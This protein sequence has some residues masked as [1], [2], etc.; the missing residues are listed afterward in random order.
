MRSKSDDMF[1]KLRSVMRAEARPASIPDGLRV[2]AIG[3][4]HGR[5]D[6]LDALLERIDADDA[7][8][9]PLE[10][11]LIF[12]GD[13]I[14]RGPDSAAVVERAIT[15]ADAAPHTCF[16]MG[17]HEE[18]FLKVLGGDLAALKFFCRIGGRE[19]ILSYG[20]TATEYDEL[21]Y[22][23]LMAAVLELVPPAHRQFLARFVDMVEIGDYVFV[24]AG[25]RP[26]L[27]LAEQKPTDLR[28]IR[29]PFLGSNARH[30]KMVV[31]G[32][33]ITSQVEVRSN[34]IGI[35]TG[36]YVTGQLT[37][38]GFEGERWWPLLAD[39]TQLQH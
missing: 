34:R 24:H 6:L 5:R 32:H 12:L 31:H 8:R 36:A 2:Y 39:A 22:E 13:L 26:D 15:I 17:N 3:D 38:L 35:D 19:T 21:D 16:L 25:I 27:P 9:A 33:T 23:G 18:V 28:W 11:R 4:V 29:E 20:L 1:K 7:Q 30:E 14:D 37:A 10:P